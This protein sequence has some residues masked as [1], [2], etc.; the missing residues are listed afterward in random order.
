MKRRSLLLKG[1]SLLLAGGPLAAALGEKGPEA[2]A[3]LLARSVSDGEV[4]GASLWLRQAGREFSQSFGTA[5]S[6]GSF[7]L[8]S[9][10]KPIAAAAV[11][12][13]HEDGAFSLDDPAQR[14]LPDFTGGGRESITVG[15]LL[16]HVSGLPDQ[17]PENDALR[18]R[19]A[20]LGDFV[21]A[22]MRTPLLFAPGERY[23]YSSMAIL[24]ATEIARRIADRP[25]A[26]LVDENV[27]RPLGME[28]SAMGVGRL[29][30]EDLLGVQTEFAAPEAGAG[31]PTAKSWDW[32]SDYWR[33]LAAPWGAAHGTAADVG[34][35][36]E[37]FLRADG[38]AL[39]PETARLMVANHNPE[40]LR[41][42]GLGFDL[43]PE[44]GGPGCGDATFGHTGSTGTRC[45]ADPG[46]GT[47]CVV[48][49]TLPSRAAAPH[50]RDLA[51]QLVAAA[52]E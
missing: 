51:S 14:F 38:R 35:F 16:T 29:R 9:I 5:A 10:S 42:R 37:S 34:R 44:L 1:S 20:P 39:R 40:G 6:G 18:A 8:G 12:R 23:G 13:L 2:A 24:L 15:Q 19:H 30:R 4:A 7:L 45:W 52:A 11:M 28:R 46:A 41:R 3:A 27:L 17:L 49:T 32:N 43:G 31:D 50:P 21:A 36:L 48:L 26:E 47:V 22:A 25:F 33:E